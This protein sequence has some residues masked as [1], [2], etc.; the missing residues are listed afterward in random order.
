MDSIETKEFEDAFTQSLKLMAKSGL[1]FIF[2]SLIAKL[3]AYAVRLVV[4][5]QG[6]SIYGAFSIGLMILNI[7]LTI[8]AA[9]LVYGAYRFIPEFEEEKDYEKSRNVGMILTVLS[10]I[11]GI[12]GG[13]IM[14]IAS[15]FFTEAFHIPNS[16]LMFQIFALSIPFYILGGVFAAIMRSIKKYEYEAGI[17]VFLENIVRIFIVFFAAWLGFG[18]IGVSAGYVFPTVISF[19][20]IGFFVLKNF[21]FL[22]A[23]PD[24]NQY[25]EVLM[26]STPLFLSGAVSLFIGWF[27]VLVIGLILSASEVGIY[28]AAMPT[29]SM[30]TAIPIALASLEIPLLTALKT[31]NK[32]KEFDSVFVKISKWIFYSTF[33]VFIFIV[34]FSTEILK[35]FFGSAYTSGALAMSIGSF[36]YLISSLSTPANDVL[37]VF[38]KT[39]LILYNIIIASIVMIGVT[40]TLVPIMGITGGAIGTATALTVN[41]ILLWFEAGKLSSENPI[42]LNYLKSVIASLLAILLA[43]G[44]YEIRGGIASFFIS[45]IIFGLVYTIMLFLLKSFD[46]FDKNILKMIAA[47]TGIKQTIQKWI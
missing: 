25:K 7:F 20:I 26:Y 28:S 45:I 17:K 4:A 23:K 41:S 22:K 27:D 33:P 2:V 15:P 42:K 37:S 40:I 43:Y 38:K 13:A 29:A 10:A 6:T 3:I 46:K 34:F 21:N 19:I 1:I 5:R 11:T 30:V 14:F 36:G 39:K 12:I 47:K 16:V 31:K 44:F 9:G 35:V 24:L 18:L 32:K 8:A